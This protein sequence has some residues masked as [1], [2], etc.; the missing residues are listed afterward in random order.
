MLLSIFSPVHGQ[1][2]DFYQF[3]SENN[4]LNEFLKPQLSNRLLPFAGNETVN[5][6]RLQV[7]IANKNDK[8]IVASCRESGASL[9]KKGR[10]CHGLQLF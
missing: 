8:A 3:L 5:K 6:K 1:D 7:A 2:G 4:S 10:S 9:F